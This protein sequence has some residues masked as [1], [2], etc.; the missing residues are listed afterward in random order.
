MINQ[1]IRYEPAIRWIKKKGYQ[2]ICEIGSGQNGICKF[3]DQNIVGVDI[4]FRDYRDDGKIDIHPNLT[5]VFGDIL[6][7]TQ[8]A[9]REFDLVVCVDMLEH[10]GKQDRER[11]IKEI[12][13]IGKNAFIA[14][15]VGKHALACD[16]WLGD[17]LVRR[18]KVPP[19]WLFE[20]LDLEFPEDGEIERILES[21]PDVSYRTFPNDNVVFHKI[22]VL[23]EILRFGRLSIRLSRWRIIQPLMRLFNGG[24]A[25][26]GIYLVSRASQ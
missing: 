1:L 2:K 14:L 15:P 22:V 18:G 24:K 12:L 19:A 8:F 21:H 6:Q 16:Q 5:P 17:V 26:R 9:D 11:A 10:I 25:Y 3:I 4:N 20:H 13:R 23:M 7:G